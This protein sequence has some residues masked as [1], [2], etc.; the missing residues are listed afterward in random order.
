[1]DLHYHRPVAEWN[2]YIH[3]GVGS[4][5]VCSTFIGNTRASVRGTDN[6]DGST[7]FYVLSPTYQLQGHT[8]M[9]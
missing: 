8:Q 7:L 4:G 2:Y 1:M 3:I 6:S 5:V 9:K